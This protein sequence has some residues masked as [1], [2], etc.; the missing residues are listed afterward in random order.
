MCGR[1]SFFSKD[2]V[3]EDRFHA[4]IKMPLKRHYNAAPSQKL[5]VILNDE[6]KNIVLGQWGLIPIWAQKKDKPKGFINARVETMAEK[7]SFRNAVK[8]HRCLVLADNFFEW[9]RKAS[10][11]IPYRIML[12][13][14]QPFAFAGIWEIY[15]TKTGVEIPTFS[16][17]TTP[18]ND[19]ISELHDRMPA[20]LEPKY[21]QLWI[22]TSADLG[23]ALETLKPLPEDQ[24][25]MHKVSPL[26]N[27]VRNDVPGVIAAV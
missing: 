3:L 17:I 4:Q 27:A 26:V 24:M 16:I 13:N 20:I 18:A 9:T 22:D 1:Y 12:K 15:K 21:E 10:T 5:P 23:L 19:M 25:Q 6:P 11:K 8:K 7:P 14:E 2:D